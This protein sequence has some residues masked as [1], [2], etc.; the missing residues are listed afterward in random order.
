MTKGP[1]PLHGSTIGVRIE[2]ALRMILE[3]LAQD[4]QRTLSQMARI[5][6]TEA[7]QVRLGG[8]PRVARKSASKLEASSA[9][10]LRLL[11]L[12]E[13]GEPVPAGE[14]EKLLKK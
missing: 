3:A 13:A 10:A 12:V 4:E 9:R 7:I 6:L 2:P 5:L 1:K 11:K 14:L 8:S